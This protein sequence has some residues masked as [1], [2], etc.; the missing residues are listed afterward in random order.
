MLT[1]L[2]LGARWSCEKQIAV[3]CFLGMSAENRLFRRAA[4]MDGLAYTIRVVTGS[5]DIATLHT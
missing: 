3:L 2:C 1:S 4:F 5:A